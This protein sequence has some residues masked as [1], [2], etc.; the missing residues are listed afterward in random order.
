LRRG[1][2]LKPNGIGYYGDFVN[3]FHLPIAYGM[4]GLFGLTLFVINHGLQVLNPFHLEWLLDGDRA[5][6]LLGWLFFHKAPWAFP[7]GRIDALMHPLGTT[8]GYTDSI[9]W[10]AFFAK[11]FFGWA[12]T[13]FQYTGWWLASC[14]ILLGVW[15]AKIVSAYERSPVYCALAGCVCATSPVVF[16][17]LGHIALCG[18]WV[19]LAGFYLCLRARCQLIPRRH[20]TLWLVL[21]AF[22]AG[23]HPYLAV[24]VVGLFLADLGRR[25]LI[26]K[27]IGRL[28]GAF[29]GVGGS[30]LVFGVFWLFG[31]FSRGGGGATGFG[32]YSANLLAFINSMGRSALSFDIGVKPG[33]YEG[34]GYLGVGVLFLLATAFGAHAI[35]ALRQKSWQSFVSTP[36]ALLPLL[37]TIGA[38]WAYSL[39]TPIYAG[40][41]VV[42]TAHALYEPLTFLTDPFRSSGRFLWPAVYGLVLLGLVY[43]TGVERGKWRIGLLAF[44]LV[45][46][47]VDLSPLIG[48]NRHQANPLRVR[49]EADRMPAA[50][51][52]GV[53]DVQMVPPLLLSQLGGNCLPIS[54]RHDSYLPFAYFAALEGKT[55]NSGYVARMDAARKRQA[56]ETILS[57][58]VAGK[59][60]PKDLFVVSPEYA[61]VFRWWYRGKIGCNK[62]PGYH[63]CHVGLKDSSAAEE[64]RVFEIDFRKQRTNPPLPVAKQSGLGD[65]NREGTRILGDRFRITLRGRLGNN[66][67]LELEMASPSL[68]I[69]ND[70]IILRL[71]DNSFEPVRK[72]DRSVFF[73]QLGDDAASTTIQIG[74]FTKAQCPEDPKCGHRV[75]RIVL[76]YSGGE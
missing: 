38:A 39:S 16:M 50:I 44:A 74:G 55:I 25:V 26:E 58:W 22:V 7:V 54:Y 65:V 6:H 36:Y 57:G 28:A 47:V 60:T 51:M 68:G 62:E 1:A 20:M 19:I 73:E 75:K 11:L 8:V 30:A 70:E 23:V 61:S 24:M 37:V 4:A 14:F 48:E 12:E 13:P 43:W 41:R 27:S 67:G 72:D 53:R 66:V 10:V 64:P 35:K 5:Q 2:A 29:F 18:Q 17:R 9:P 59:A 21:L 49:L 31:Y 52:A 56:C 3:R 45:A 42:A 76:R 34:Y 15:G 69:G 33:Q 46:Q 71:G 40:E 32:Y 63:L